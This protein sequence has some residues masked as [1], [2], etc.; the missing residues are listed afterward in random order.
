MKPTI[1]DGRKALRR[2][3][4]L[5][6]GLVALTLAACQSAAPT[7][8]ADAGGN[9]RDY[10]ARFRA[11]EAARASLAIRSDCASACTIFLGLRRVSVGP[12][13]RFWFHAARLPGDDRPDPLGSLQMLSFYPEAV[14]KWA[15]RVKALE[16]AEFD[17]SRM[18]TGDDLARMGVPRCP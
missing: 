3:P 10:I 8:V 12:G 4:S 15:I 2:L 18:L 1:E 11:I 5:S 9:L 7:D 13:A 16:S 6:A 14:R 17:P